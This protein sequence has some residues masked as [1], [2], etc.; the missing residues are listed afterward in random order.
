M[1]ETQATLA[2]LDE[3]WK[4]E[5]T[6]RELYEGRTQGEVADYL[7]ERGHD[8]T[9]STISYW[10]KKLEVNTTHTSHDEDER[11]EGGICAKC[12]GETP[13]PNNGM[14]VPC[15]DRARQKQRAERIENQDEGYY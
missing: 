9:A 15:L 3:P 5:S 6:L 7:K 11:E 2:G 10:M 8:V 4:D 14:C 1:S 12:D 13:G